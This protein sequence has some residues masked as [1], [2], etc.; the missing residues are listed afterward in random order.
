MRLLLQLILEYLQRKLSEE[1]LHNI[2]L[3]GRLLFD[4]IIMAYRFENELSDD[5]GIGKIF[6]Q[7]LY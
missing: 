5:K 1:T 2:D 6:D 4:M 7:V 3:V